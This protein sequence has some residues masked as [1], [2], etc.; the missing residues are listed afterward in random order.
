MQEVTRSYGGSLGETT[1]AARRLFLGSPSGCRKSLRN[2]SPSQTRECP[3][4]CWESSIRCP[5]ML[6]ILDILCYVQLNVFLKLKDMKWCHET[7][8]K[9]FRKK[10]GL[11]TRN[12]LSKYSL[13]LSC[14]LHVFLHKWWRYDYKIMG[15]TDRVRVLSLEM[16]A[17][18]DYLGLILS[19]RDLR[20]NVSDSAIV[21]VHSCSHGREIYH[22]A[23]L[24]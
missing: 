18:P 10:Q 20:R 19:G 11:A 16:K 15:K 1:P 17:R 3:M 6:H 4:W 21:H 2:R 13:S 5:N 8:N 23:R 14:S 24:F 7:C 22:L 9:I 12:V